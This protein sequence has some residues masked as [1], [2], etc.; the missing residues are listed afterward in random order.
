MHDEDKTQSTKLRARFDYSYSILFAA[1][2]KTTR[3]W[4]NQAEFNS[5]KITMCWRLIPS[6]IFFLL[7]QMS[8]FLS[9]NVYSRVLLYLQPQTTIKCYCRLFE[10]R[11]DLRAC[12]GSR[13]LNLTHWVLGI[14]YH[15]YFIS[16]I[17]GKLQFK[18]YFLWAVLML[19]VSDMQRGVER[20]YTWPDPCITSRYTISVLRVQYYEAYKNGSTF[21]SST[22]MFCARCVQQS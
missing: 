12:Y 13:F 7:S 16:I 17:L 11:R 18:Q 22:D 1:I 19:H 3:A 9:P 5:S 15:N 2:T 21:F 8:S 6:V 20:S 10:T 4:A 14:S